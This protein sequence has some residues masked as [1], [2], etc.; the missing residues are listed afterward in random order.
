LTPSASSLL[1]D[2]IYILYHILPPL[3]PSSPPLSSAG[4]GG[5][6]LGDASTILVDIVLL[7]LRCQQRG[8][9]PS[10]ESGW[11][12]LSEALSRRELPSVSPLCAASS[13]RLARRAL[14]APPL[15]PAPPLET[16]RGLTPDDHPQEKRYRSMQEHIRRAHPEHYISK[17]PATEESFQL[18][19]NTPP[20]ERPPPQTSSPTP[21]ALEAWNNC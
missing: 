10:A 5:V 19:I 11:L 14:L 2:F 1:C 13:Y 16:D 8:R 12:W 6:Y 4:N 21:T 3:L 9:L 20:S 15:L 17:L 7:R 18:M